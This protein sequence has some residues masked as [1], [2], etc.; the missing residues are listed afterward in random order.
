VRAPLP[1]AQVA[2]GG[3]VGGIA[4]EVVATHPL[5][6]DDL[7]RLQRGDGLLNLWER[8]LWERLLWERLLWEQLLWEQLLWERL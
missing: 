7:A 4:D 1:V 8:L 2:H 6:R 3:V 5:D